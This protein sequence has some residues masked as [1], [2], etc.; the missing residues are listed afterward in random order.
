ML[1]GAQ[2]LGVEKKYKC[3][4][5]YYYSTATKEASLKGAQDALR[6]AKLGLQAAKKAIEEWKDVNCK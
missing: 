3:G 2:Y 1:L 4:F 5:W 6:G